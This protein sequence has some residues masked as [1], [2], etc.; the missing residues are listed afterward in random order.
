[1]LITRTSPVTK[2]T[3][4]LDIDITEEQMFQWLHGKV[5]QEAM[6]NISADEREFIK[7]GLCPDYW[8]YLMGEEE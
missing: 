6:P 4:S 5:I 2:V 8:E 7:T 3:V 1:M